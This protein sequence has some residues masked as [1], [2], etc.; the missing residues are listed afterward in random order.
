VSIS[1]TFYEQLLC[2]YPFVKKLQT[3]IVSTEKLH[4]KLS[5][6]NAARKILVK[7]T[8]GSAMTLSIMT[9]CLKDLILS[10]KC[11]GHESFLGE[12]W[13]ET[14]FPGIENTAI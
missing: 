4:K 6:E 9:F 14:N 5:Y 7:L 8:P 12:N 10:F 13:R 11:C 1:P 3:Q 2:Q